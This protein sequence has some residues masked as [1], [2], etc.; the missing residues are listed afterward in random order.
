MFR[1]TV[2]GT[3]LAVLLACPVAPSQVASNQGQN[4]ER[5]KALVVEGLKAAEMNDYPKAEQEFL[6]AVREAEIFGPRDSRVGVTL[7]SLGLAY[8]AEHK[9][10]DAESSY[11][12]GL[13]IIEIALPNS[14]DVANVNYNLANVMFDEGRHGDALPF[15]QRARTIYE[16][17]LGA[18]SLKTAAIL[19]MEGEADRVAK[20]YL[21]AE[22]PLRKCADIREED[23]GLNSA[24]LA[25][26][27]QSL[28]RTFAAE[29][30]LSIAESRYKLVESIREKTAGITSPLLAEAMEEHA[31]VLK[32]LGRDK[33]A[34]KLTA[35][36]SA[37]RKSQAKNGATP[38]K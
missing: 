29:G 36:S 19:C 13:A 23:S 31:A 8:R 5:W 34:E 9:Y 17:Q 35:M 6:K 20:R 3:V 38:K 7:N 24:D 21:Q 33:E 28:A 2:A 37:I 12:R 11:R 26:A 14:I 10:S 22:G 15:I 27:L 18:T 32:S 25:D 30:K 16:K 4:D 1:I